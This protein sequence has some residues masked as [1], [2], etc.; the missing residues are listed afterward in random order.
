MI[1]LTINKTGLEHNIQKAKENHIIIP[2]IAQMQNP[3]LIPEKIKAKLSHTG[4]WDVD[5]VNL[6]RISWHNE[7]KEQGGL[8]QAVPNYVEIPSKLSGVPCRIIAMSGKWFP[9]GCHKVGAS[10]GCLAPRLVTGQFDATYHHAVWPSTGNYCRGG[11]FNSKLLACESVAILPQDMSKERFDWLKSI[12]GQIIA[13]PGCESNVKDLRQNLGAEEGPHHDD[14][15]P[16]RRDGQPPVA[17]QRH[18]LRPGRAVR[19]REEAR[20]ELRRRLLHLRF[21]RHH[22][23]R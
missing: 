21:R 1:D 12:A 3:D 22:V 10:F 6:F 4:L 2:T 19:G 16:V 14:L 11:A 15:Q 23:R 13:T 20:P 17:L 9:T 18:R 7:A 8:F 5:P